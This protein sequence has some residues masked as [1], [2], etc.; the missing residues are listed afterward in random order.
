VP[1]VRVDQA[2]VQDFQHVR[3]DI[4]QAEP[5]D[6][7]RHLAH[8]VHARLQLQRPVEEIRL[9]RAEDAL[10]RQGAAGQQGGGVVNRQVQHPR[11]DR[12]HHDREIGVL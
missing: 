4:A 12:F 1:L 3:L 11:R 8:Q 10:V 9:D 5:G 2:F 6:F 7:P